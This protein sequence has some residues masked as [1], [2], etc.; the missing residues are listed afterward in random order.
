MSDGTPSPEMIESP[1]WGTVRMILK[2]VMICCIVLA[3]IPYYSH[4]ET[5]DFKRWS[6][7]LGLPFSPWIDFTIADAKTDGGTRHSSNAGI[8]FISVSFLLVIVGFAADWAERKLRS[9]S[10]VEARDS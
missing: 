8:E 2:V 6:F 9:K 10:P 3:L 4:D 5:A 7:R 1:R